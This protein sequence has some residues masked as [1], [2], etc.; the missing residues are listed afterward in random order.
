MKQRILNFLKSDNNF[1]TSK[2][3]KQHWRQSKYSYATDP[4]PDH[5]IMLVLRGNACFV[6]EE[7]TITATA[8][9][10]LFLPKGS[11]YEA[12]F[13]D[14]IDDYLVSFDAH[15][16]GLVLSSPVKL[17]ERAPFYCIERFSELVSENYSETHTIL[18]SRGLFYL[19][20]DVIANNIESENDEHRKLVMYAMELLRSKELSIGEVAKECAV[21][22]SALRYIFKEQ[23]TMSPVQYR[24]FARI[25]QA[26]YLLESTGKSISEI[27]EELGFF[28]VAYFCKVFK[29]HMG[30]T[31]KQYSQNKNI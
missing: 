1:Y 23:T 30:V 18:H 11:R 26:A 22:E 7:E 6:T 10:V 25:K 20:L 28:D 2:I 17:I 15:G 16:E 29:K 8:G 19:L 27:S 13:P 31:P 4:R 9:N 12:V 3:L 5:G 24:L 14:E 21:S